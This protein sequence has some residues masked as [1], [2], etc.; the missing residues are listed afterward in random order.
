VGHRLGPGLLFAASSVGTSHLVQSTRAG[1]DYGLAMFGLILLACFIKYPAFRFGT[2]YAAATGSTLVDSYFRQGRWAV[3]VYTLEVLVTMFVATAA[4]GIVSA[5]LIN[6]VLSLAIPA[7]WLTCGLLVLCAA[8]LISGRYQLFEKLTKG[9][10]ALFM[11]LILVAVGLTLPKLQIQATSMA[12]VLQPEHSTLLFMVALAGWMPTAISA[13]VFQSLWVC[14]KSK[15]LGRP[16]TLAE[17]RFDFNFGYISTILLAFCFMVLGAVLMFQPGEA[18]ADN[19]SG[20]ATQLISLFTQSIGQFAYPIIA[21]VAVAVMLSTLLAL[22]DAC[23]RAVGAMLTYR[24]QSGG[25]AKTLSI[26][27]TIE[28]SVAHEDRFYTLLLV[29]QCLGAM[30][31]LM[32]FMSSFKDFIDFATSVAFLTAPVLAVMNHRAIYAPEVPDSARPSPLMRLWSLL[33]IIVMGL[34]GLCYIYFG[35]L[36]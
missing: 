22:L 36:N 16:L 1:A 10:V 35:I 7:R 26:E 28:Q 19:A 20:F 27:A 23:P 14:A 12:P 9:L 4:V 11:V 31:V 33:G 18:V 30:T 17:A 34:F 24:K 21:L 29:A 13:S 3:A 2:D 25:S 15:A 32:L 8:V 5:G 6:S